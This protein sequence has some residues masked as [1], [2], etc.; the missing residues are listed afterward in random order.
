MSARAIQIA[1]QVFIREPYVAH[2]WMYVSGPRDDRDIVARIARLGVVV[3]TL[4]NAVDADVVLERMR[5]GTLTFEQLLCSS[6]S[7]LKS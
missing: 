1:D 5:R 2:T 6:S 3:D 7:S 4:S